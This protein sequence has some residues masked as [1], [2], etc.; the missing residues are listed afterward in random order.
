MFRFLPILILLAACSED[1]APQNT[2]TAAEDA[3]VDLAFCKG[4]PFAD[5]I[6]QPVSN[7]R[8]ELPERSR[9][10]GP[11]D[12]ATQDYRI[13]R[14]NVYVNDAGIIQRLTCG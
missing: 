4:E 2:T 10:L 7:M 6:G 5:A 13:D 1:P 12:I 3:P 11:D 14:L 9:V 8:A